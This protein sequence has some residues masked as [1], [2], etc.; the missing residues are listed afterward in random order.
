M[1]IILASSS[2]RRIEIMK[3]AGFSFETAV[4]THDEE[5]NLHLPVIEYVQ[6]CAAGK[7]KPV[8]EENRDA[9]VIG[10]DTV[11]FLDGEVIGKPRDRADAEKMLKKMSGKTHKVLTGLSIFYGGKSFSSYEETGVTFKK[12]G[13]AELIWYLNRAD[14]MDKAGAYA[15]QEEASFFIERI[16]GDYFNVVGFPVY[17]FSLLF[18]EAAGV[19][20][21]EAIEEACRK[22]GKEK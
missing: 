15:I 22:G 6:Q 7:A 5:T 9:L 1:K 2:K 16:D 20:Y 3:A 8:A 17:R 14:Y 11:V 10:A 21:F 13:E 4:H 19:E 12:I 18:K